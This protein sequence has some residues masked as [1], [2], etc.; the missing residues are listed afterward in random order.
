[1]KIV[2]HNEY[3]IQDKVEMTSCKL[4]Q[5]LNGQCGKQYTVKRWTTSLYDVRS[6]NCIR[7]MFTWKCV[8]WLVALDSQQ[9]SL[10]TIKG[11]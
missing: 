11:Y 7:T 2:K 6:A 8:F 5:R 1:M 10:V 4:V 3:Y 9:G